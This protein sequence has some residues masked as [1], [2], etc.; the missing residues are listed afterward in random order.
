MS[1]QND[2]CFFSD[3]ECLKSDLIVACTKS[4]GAAQNNWSKTVRVL[5]FPRLLHVHLTACL[6]II[7]TLTSFSDEGL[8][9]CSQGVVLLPLNVLL[10]HLDLLCL[11]WGVLRR[12]GWRVAVQTFHHGLVLLNDGPIRMLRL[13]QMTKNTTSLNNTH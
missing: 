13:N 11:L 1:P 3:H 8:I 2:A 5:R 6:Y 4:N 9:F 12:N 7:P 10:P